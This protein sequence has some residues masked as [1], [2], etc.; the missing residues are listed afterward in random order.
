MLFYFSPL[1]QRSFAS[2]PYITNMK[3]LLLLSALLLFSSASAQISDVVTPDPINNPLHQANIGRITFMNG[4]IPIEQYQSS[5]FLKNFDLTYRSDLN[6]RVFMDNSITNYLHRLAPEWPAE[7]LIGLGNYQFSFYVDGNLIYTEN[8]HPGA[9][10]NKDRAT[11]FR[12]PLTST[13]GEDWW[14][15]YLWDRFKANGGEKALT[16]GSHLLKIEIRPYLKKEG[17]ILIGG[18]IAQGELT[19]VLKPVVVSAAEIAMQPIKENSGWPLSKSGY[20]VKTIEA[21]NTKIAEHA[22]KEISSIVVISEGKLLIEEYFNGADR[23]TLHDTRSVGKSFAS[24]LMGMAIQ[25]GYITNEEVKLGTLYNLQQY[26][27]SAPKKADV[28]IKDLLTMSSAFEGSDMDGGSPGNEENMYPAENWVKFA[29]DLPM[30][31]NKTNGAQWDYFTAGVVLLGDIINKAVP[32]GLEKYAEKKLFQPLGISN[33]Q[34]QY[35]PQKVPNT[36]GSLQLSALDLAKYG[37]LYQNKGKWNGKQILSKE[38]AAKT[39]TR[40]IIIPQRDNE[41]YGYLF[42]NKTYIANGKAY[43]TF[44]CSGNGGNRIIVFKDV[45]LTIVITAKAYNKPYAHSQT[46]TIVSQYLLPAV[47]H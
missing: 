27:H 3:R 13:K 39:L 10:V 32:D 5:D 35:T 2:N 25:D 20:D 26:A 16:E 36:A 12:V 14:A 4:N 34:W 24:T 8:V 33:F 42:W 45:P 28:K 9:G 40:Q 21:L 47:L 23:N 29:L 44:Y 6:I 37:Q 31:D 38:W 11:V 30:D 17:E 18:L 43:E 19:L 1:L 46:D 41:F 7:T 22:F 15:M